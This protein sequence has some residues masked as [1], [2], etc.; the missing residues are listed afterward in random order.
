MTYHS[1]SGRAM[2]HYCG[3]SIKI[4]GVCPECGSE[5]LFTETPG[6]QKLEEEL[7]ERFPAARV[8]RMDA[9]TMTAKGAHERLLSKFGRGEADI[10]LGTQM[11]TKGLDFENVTL[12]GVLGTPTRA[13][14]RRITARGSG[15]FRSSRRWSAARDGGSIQDAPLSRRTARCTRSS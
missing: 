9:D 2:C 1:V 14:T 5:S 6:T 3:A 7:H 12:V 10:L 11:V 13:C 8:L 15:R 4:T